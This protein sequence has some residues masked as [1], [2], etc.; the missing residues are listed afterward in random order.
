MTDIKIVDNLLPQGY[1]D[2][3]ERDLTQFQFPWYYADDVTYSGY[4]NNGGLAHLVYNFGNEP[5]SYYAFFKPII[6]SIEAAHGVK[7]RDLLRIRVGMLL[8][9]SKPAE[10]YNTPHVDFTANHYTACY[11]A[12][13]TDGDTVL[14]NEKLNDLVP[15][16]TNITDEVITH[17]TNTTKFT[18][19]FRSTPKKNRVC[20]FDGLRFHSSSHPREHEKRFVITINYTA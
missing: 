1:A 9:S 3:I 4:N 6:Y 11:Y 17:Y 2:Q 5:S 7:I 18:E 14:F 10:V 15:Q 12:N 13:D 16:N 19:A 20:I 8:T